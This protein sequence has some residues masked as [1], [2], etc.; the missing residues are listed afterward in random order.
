MSA[1]RPPN[2]QREWQSRSLTVTFHDW[3]DLFVTCSS[4]PETIPNY[5]RYYASP[6]IVEFFD[7]AVLARSHV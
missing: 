4:E 6:L 7:W 5:A 2:V 1:A 3:P